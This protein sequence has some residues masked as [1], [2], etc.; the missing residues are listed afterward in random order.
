MSEPRTP[1]QRR[2]GLAR[3]AYMHAAR[4]GRSGGPGSYDKCIDVIAALFL[5]AESAATKKEQE[6]C[7]DAVKEWTFGPR[8]REILKII[9]GYDQGPGNTE[10]TTD[11]Q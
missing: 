8:K 6:R 10:E 2:D 5:E 1:E 9:R 4:N 11:E 7:V 3:H